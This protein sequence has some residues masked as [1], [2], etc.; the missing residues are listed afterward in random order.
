MNP[1]KKPADTEFNILSLGVGV[2]SSCVAIMAA[3]GEITPTP[4]FA[5]FSD[6][7]AE[8]TEVYEYLATLRDLIAKEKHPFPIYIVSKGDLTKDSLTMSKATSRAKLYEEGQE[9]ARRLIPIFGIMPNGDKT[10]AI[11]RKCTSDYKIAPLE[12]KVKE[13]CGIKRGEKEVKVTQW[14]GIS[15]DEIQRAK[16]N[17]S[18]WAQMR[19]PLLEMQMTRAKILEWFKLHGYPEPPRSACFYCPFHS[20]TEW[21]RMRDNDK[22]HFD[23]A[24]QFDRDIRSHFKKDKSM[25]MTVYLHNSCK[26]LDE[27]DFDNDEDKGQLGWDFQSECEGMCGV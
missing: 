16:E 23:K 9:Y 11:G 12:K 3:R 5:I 14:I 18:P 22:E 24:I 20:D 6:V 2:Q 25:K 10:A 19:F 13:L 27:V 26:P 1:F 17:R 21:R 4:D 8:P 15:W 7:G